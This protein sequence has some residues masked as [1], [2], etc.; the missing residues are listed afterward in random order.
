M[1]I[2][3]RWR[4]VAILFALALAGCN[5]GP[6]VS[7]ANGGSEILIRREA[8]VASGALVRL[9][10]LSNNIDPDCSSIRRA[11]VRVAREP[12]HGRLTIVRSV[13]YPGFSP[14]NP[15]AHCNGKGT[16][17]AKVEYR[18]TPGFQGEDLVEYEIWTFNGGRLRY[19]A[20]IHV[21]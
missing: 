8:T 7:F 15:R 13:V 11:D 21:L 5:V 10:T 6:Q 20:V 12:Q 9:H 2:S 18:S 3:R 4:C 16:Q 17:G 1:K 14:G 19:T